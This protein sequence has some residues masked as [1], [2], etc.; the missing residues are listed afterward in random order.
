[1]LAGFLLN[2]VANATTA[3]DG[4]WV[5][6]NRKNRREHINKLI[7]H[8]K[9]LREQWAER[10][11]IEEELRLELKSAYERMYA[12]PE[13]KEVIEKLT[14]PYESKNPQEPVNWQ[15]MLNAKVDAEKVLNLYQEI[16]D[17][18]AIVLLIS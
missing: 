12:I 8:D 6:R 11:R 9:L 4:G 17:E 2:Q 7:E 13:K 14:K 16:I 10:N 3:A 1:M 18:E 15:W 5:K